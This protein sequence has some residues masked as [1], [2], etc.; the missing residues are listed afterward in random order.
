MASVTTEMKI[1]MTNTDHSLMAKDTTIDREM[2]PLW[3]D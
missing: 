2:P 1:M 3:V